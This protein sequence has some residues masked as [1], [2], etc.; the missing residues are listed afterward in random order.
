MPSSIRRPRATDEPPALSVIVVNYNAGPLLTDCVSAVLDSPVETEILISDNGSSDGSLRALRERFGSDPRV[1]LVENGRNLGFAAASNRVLAR[2]R[3]PYLLFLNPDCLVGPETL[4]RM[5]VFMETTPDAG[6]AGCL[7]RNPDGTEQVASRRVIPDPWIG[8]VRVLHLDRWMPRLVATKRLDRRHEP[9]PEQ[10]VE[11]EA[12][13]GAF[14]MARR[15]ALDEIGPL[16]AGYFLHCEDLDWF[17]RCAQTGWKLYLVPDAEV[18][19]YKGTC[20]ASRSLFVDWHKHRGMVRFFR[21][22]QLSRY[23]LPLGVLVIL[24]IWMRFALVS[25]GH[26]VRDSGAWIRRQRPYD[27][28]SGDPLGSAKSRPGP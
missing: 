22:H 21:R 2:A 12:I 7:V 27:A 14:I 15:T 8:L 4:R 16:D 11:A 3:A 10:P 25:V 17:V 9:L 28:R 13:S 19:H 1:M 5:L 23:P 6:L 18:I 24:G 26:A 20:S